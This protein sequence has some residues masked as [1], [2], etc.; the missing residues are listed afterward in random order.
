[1]AY[2]SIEQLRYPSEPL[3]RVIYGYT[4]TCGAQERFLVSQTPRVVIALELTESGH[5]GLVEYSC[6]NGIYSALT[7]ELKDIARCFECNENSLKLTSV[8][9]IC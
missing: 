3:S 4:C 5:L 1:M 2:H 6:Q 7:G 9:D 8:A